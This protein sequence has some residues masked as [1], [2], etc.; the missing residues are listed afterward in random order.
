[1][2]KRIF[3]FI[4]F[5]LIAINYTKAQDSLKTF[6]FMYMQPNY[7]VE[8]NFPI[9]YV[10]TGSGAMDM[11]VKPGDIVTAVEGLPV[12]SYTGSSL[13]A[14]IDKGKQ[15]G[16]LQITLARAAEPLVIKVKTIARYTRLDCKDCKKDED[17]FRDN[18]IGYSYKGQVKNGKLNGKGTILYYW[19]NC[20]VK[21]KNSV[22][23]NKVDAIFTDNKP[24]QGIYYYADESGFV[25]AI[26][27]F[28][29]NAPYDNNWPTGAGK[30]EN[31]EGTIMEGVFDAEGSKTGLFRFDKENGDKFEC[32]YV[33]NVAVSRKEIVNANGAPLKRVAAAA[34]ATDLVPY[35]FYAGGNRDNNALWGYKNKAGVVVIKPINKE[36][37]LFKN[38]YCVLVKDKKLGLMDAAGTIIIESA[39]Y[40]LLSDVEGSFVTVKNFKTGCTVRNIYDSTIIDITKGMTKM[41]KD[42]SYNKEFD[43]FEYE[44]LTTTVPNIFLVKKIPGGNSGY[45]SR[46]ENTRYG[47]INAKD[48]VLIPFTYKRIDEPG[49]GFLR[50]ED[51]NGKEGLINNVGNWVVKPGKY[52][53]MGRMEEG[54][55][56]VSINGKYGYINTE[57][58]EIHPCTLED[59]SDFKNGYAR[60]KAGGKNYFIDKKAKPW[61]QGHS[62]K[63]IY[64][65]KNNLFIVTKQNNKPD[66]LVNAKGE[67]QLKIEAEQVVFTTTGYA[68]LAAGK[69]VIN[70]G[71]E[72]KLPYDSIT[73]ITAYPNGM[74][75][76][77]QTK[78]NSYND[79]YNLDWVVDKTGK[80]IVESGKTGKNF[81]YDAKLNLL[82]KVTILTRNIQFIC[83][84]DDK[85][86]DYKEVG[87]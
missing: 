2:C 8:D 1:M 72:I 82:K 28:N 32:N 18:I 10:V 23:I 12:L 71:K 11:G 46:E 85:G 59:A 50:V 13:I 15:K 4:S 67:G 26:P 86:K 52:D 14:A 41:E 83:Y 77:T 79:S 40:Y 24:G 51:M 65:G 54:M 38:N 47:L 55:A 75:M 16:H 84:V 25:G 35:Q 42:K 21:A 87:K 31:A 45:L 22:R 44:T 19:N 69:V 3:L 66:L 17:Y 48:S 39:D 62:F 29:V 27:N 76:L 36:P 30:F 7:G 33:S 78:K 37:R 53:G 68:Y 20:P 5:I 74:L 34:V 49:E 57:G 60:V 63:Y 70:N 61:L 81:E 73:K 58:K 43:G 80:L 6:G 64:E 56:F 9:I